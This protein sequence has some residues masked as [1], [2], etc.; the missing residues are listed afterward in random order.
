MADT[1]ARR[2]A[3]I[4]GGV[5]S[6]NEV[7]GS[8]TNLMVTY[9][10]FGEVDL[11]GVDLSATAILNDSWQVSVGGSL[12]SDDFFKL[13]LAGQDSQAVALNAPKR[14]ATASLTYRN[15]LNGLSAEGRVRYTDEFP[16]NSAGY[17][18]LRCV[19]PTATG[20]CVE[21]F[22]VF[23]CDGGLPPADPRCI[24]AAFGEQPVR[25]GLPQLHR[26]AAAW[27]HGDLASALRHVVSRGVAETQ[28]GH[29]ISSG[30]PSASLRLCVKLL[31]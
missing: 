20:E 23:E 19:E 18:G 12:V 21:S 8:G 15:T 13:P 5:V 3:R 25:C 16:A 31:S 7:N 10:N 6:S 30:G 9:V 24:A 2:L 29:R 28:R 14:K 26:H 1:I 22:T 27:P 11:S 17:V 4:P